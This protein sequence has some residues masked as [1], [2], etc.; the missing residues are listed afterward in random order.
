MSDTIDY[1]L[2]VFWYQKESFNS[3]LQKKAIQKF[4]I[5]K[6]PKPETPLCKKCRYY[7]T[8]DKDMSKLNKHFEELHFIDPIDI[9]RPA[10]KEN[11]VFP[12]L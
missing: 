3:L 10:I 12:V 7:V 2:L 1:F 8:S 4:S 5:E 11:L 9:S 6:I